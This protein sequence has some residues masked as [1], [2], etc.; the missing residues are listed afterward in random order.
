MSG[1]R[2]HRHAIERASRRQ[3]EGHDSAPHRHAIEQASH[4]RRGGH[5]SAVL[6]TR[7]DN[8]ISTRIGTTH[9]FPLYAHVSS[10]KLLDFRAEPKTYSTQIFPAKCSIFETASCSFSSPTSRAPRH[11]SMT[12]FISTSPCGVRRTDCTV[13]SNF[14]AVSSFI[15]FSIFLPKKRAYAKCTIFLFKP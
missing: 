6:E 5:D 13:F 10:F 3:R 11:A 2:P 1:D 9:P 12:S 7:R 4:R 15:S 14:R 8:L